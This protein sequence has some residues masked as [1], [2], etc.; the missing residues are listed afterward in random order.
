MSDDTFQNKRDKLIFAAL[1][2]NR[3]EPMQPHHVSALRERLD[4]LTDEELLEF[5]HTGVWPNTKI[6]G[7]S[8]SLSSQ[9]IE[10]STMNEILDFEKLPNRSFSIHKII[11][12]VEYASYE[13]SAFLVRKD[14]ER[15]LAEKIMDN[16]IFYQ[17]K[18]CNGGSLEIKA[19]VIILTTEEYKDL[20]REAFNKGVTKG[21]FP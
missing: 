16:N 7:V 6:E 20:L 10:I 11:S 18:E 5:V 3:F 9:T 8:K 2:L 21:L 4:Y 19:N 13:E 14:V 15:L 17:C 12:A 1:L